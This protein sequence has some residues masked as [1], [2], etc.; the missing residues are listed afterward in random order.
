MSL[1]LINSSYFVER[2]KKIEVKEND[3]NLCSFDLM[4]YV[5]LGYL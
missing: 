4:D 3:A 5:V 2:E 1:I